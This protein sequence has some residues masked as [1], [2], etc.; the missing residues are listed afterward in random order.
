MVTHH[1]MAVGPIPEQFVCS[2]TRDV[3]YPDAY[4]TT[5]DER[6]AFIA[7]GSYASAAAAMRAMAVAGDADLATFAHDS[8]QR[9]T[10]SEAVALGM[11][12]ARIARKLAG[13]ETRQRKP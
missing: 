10:R 3:I 9:Y 4:R 12:A 1:A 7:R 13:D 8:V 6:L 2:C 11:R 5:L